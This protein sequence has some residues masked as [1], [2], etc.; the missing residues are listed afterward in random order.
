MRKPDPMKMPATALWGVRISD[1]DLKK[2]KAGYIPEDQDDKWLFYA[3]EEPLTVHIVRS[4][5]H[6]DCYV[7]HIVIKP[8]D[9]SSSG[10]SAEI[11]SITWETNR[12]C[13][14]EERAKKDAVLISRT[15]LECDF[16]ALPE[17]EFES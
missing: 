7:L 11:A 9:D 5:L 15:V 13:L 17:Y 6:V 10:S 14:T 1:T 12:G 16:D 2:L 3:T 8:G 4:A